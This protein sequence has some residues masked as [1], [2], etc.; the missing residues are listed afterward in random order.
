VGSDVPWE[1]GPYT[2]YIF[3]ELENVREGAQKGTRQETAGIK[4]LKENNFWS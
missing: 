4:L 3:Q 2:D 1:S